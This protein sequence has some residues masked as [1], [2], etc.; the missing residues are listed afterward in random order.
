MIIIP[1]AALSYGH[2]SVKASI[3]LLEAEA[4]TVMMMMTQ[5][6]KNLICALLPHKAQ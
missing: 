2:H 3:N 5:L 6:A 1:G 4:D